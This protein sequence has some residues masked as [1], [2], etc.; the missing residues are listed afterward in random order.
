MHSI[1]WNAHAATLAAL[2]AAG[3]AAGAAA[4][5][6][7][8][9][10]RG[11]AG[12]G[13]RIDT[14]FAFSPSGEVL[15][16]LPA[17]EINVTG[18]NRNEIRIIAV[19]ER[20]E[21]GASYSSSRVRIEMRSRTGN[22]GTTRYDVTVPA[23]ARVNASALSGR[24]T[25]TGTRGEMTLTSASGGITAS[26]AVGRSSVE[27]MSGRVT[28]QRFE[29]NTRIN[30]LAG[31]VSVNDV[32][33][34]LDVEIVSGSVRVDRAALDALR[35]KGMTGQL[36][37]G[38]TLGTQARHTVE[39]HTGGVILRLPAEFGATIEFESFLGEMRSTDFPV[40]LR[41]GAANDRGR[42]AQRQQ[43]EINGG[44]ARISIQT[45]NGGVELR[46]LGAPERR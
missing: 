9:Q 17:G 43:Y 4:P 24:I 35:Y 5:A 33:G 27:T 18:W 7:A 11:A 3:A 8:Q 29:G 40:V 22:T 19:S 32:K 38:G 25:V 16:S 10:T 31:S 15:L 41:P 45:F 13:T 28:L 30:A 36:D 1:R 26:D 14:T 23:G 20:G 44:G 6:T 2:L 37:F 46:R 34:E 39:T 21:L 42:D 12:S